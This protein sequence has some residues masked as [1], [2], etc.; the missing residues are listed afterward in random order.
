MI[1]DKRDEGEE[2]VLLELCLASEE[3]GVNPPPSFDMPVLNIITKKKN[4]AF[5]IHLC[6]VLSS[7]RIFP[8]SYNK[9]SSKNRVK[10]SEINI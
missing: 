9:Q 2:Q 8:R 5:F 7:N 4:N 6:A 3:G 1:K 10:F